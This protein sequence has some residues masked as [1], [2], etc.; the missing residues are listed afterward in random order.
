MLFMFGEAIWET[1]FR[2]GAL[3]L[4]FCTKMLDWIHISATRLGSET[5]IQ[6]NEFFYASGNDHE[7]NYGFLWQAYDLQIKGHPYD[8]FQLHIC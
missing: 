5:F 4:I 6:K 3:K 7:T 1:K 8:K 2:T